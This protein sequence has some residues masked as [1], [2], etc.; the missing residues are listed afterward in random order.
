MNNLKVTIEKG[1]HVQTLEGDFIVVGVVRS[2]EGGKQLS[3][4]TTGNAN[5][6]EASML[7]CQLAA[8]LMEPFDTLEKGS[9]YAD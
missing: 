3:V 6:Y 9:I 5:A 1:P 7:G 8:K 2:T 4:V